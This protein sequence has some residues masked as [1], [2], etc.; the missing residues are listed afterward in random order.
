MTVRVAVHSRNTHSAGKPEVMDVLAETIRKFDIVA[1]QEIRNKAGTAITKLRN[2]VN[3]TGRAY[4]AVTGA[5][6][7]H[8]MKQQYAYLYDTA[9]VEPLDGAYDYD[10]DGDGDG[11]NDADDEAG[12]DWFEREPYVHGFRAVAGD[13]DFVL[14]NIYADPD[15]AG[16]LDVKH[17]H[18]IP[19]KSVCLHPLFR[20]FGLVLRA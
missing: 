3:E 19:K 8:N 15:I 12:G 14:V 10:D 20:N 13:F 11:E 9:K 16:K 17:E 4:E 7:G 1:I 5:R 18:A 2:K 6:V